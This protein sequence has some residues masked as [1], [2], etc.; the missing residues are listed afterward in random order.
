M[1]PRTRYYYFNLGMS[2]NFLLEINKE[3]FN[4]GISKQDFVRALIRDYFLRNHG[5]DIT[6][7]T[8]ER[9]K[10]FPNDGE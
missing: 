7:K 1:K 4:L 9:L 5:K 8:N 6:L 2:R 10:N 3:C